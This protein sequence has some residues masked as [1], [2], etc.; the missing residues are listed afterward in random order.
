[1]AR[2]SL[3]KAA[4]VSQGPRPRPPR[5]SS[6]A[7]KPEKLMGWQARLRRFTRQAV[8]VVLKSGTATNNTVWSSVP[9]KNPGWSPS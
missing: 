3:D 5:S 2:A 7:P 9:A 1:M 8:W 4:F 6:S